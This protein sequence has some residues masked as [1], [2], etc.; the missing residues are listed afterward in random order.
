MKIIIINGSYRKNGATASVLTEIYGQLK[1]NSDVDIQ[2]YHVSD[3]NLKYCVGCCKCYKTGKCI[4]NDDIEELSLNIEQADG[5]IVGSPTYASNVSGQLKTII[6]RGHFVVEQLLYGKYAIV[7]TT[8]EN[9]GGRDTL[10][11]LNRLLSYSGASLS[12][13]I[14]LKLPFSSNPLSN[15]NLKKSIQKKVGKFYRDIDKKHKYPFQNLKHFIVF[16]MGIQPFVK[17]NKDYEGVIKHW[18][19]HGIK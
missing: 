11:I 13:N 16:H 6:D 19:E 17:K 14:L 2:I 18:K 3:M 7:V 9:Y 15:T 12:G 4:F 8:Y 1:Q 5:I 10:K